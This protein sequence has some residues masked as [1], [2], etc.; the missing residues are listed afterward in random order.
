MAEQADLDGPL[1]DYA[2]KG[3]QVELVGRERVEG[4]DAFKLRVTRKDGSVEVYFLDAGSYLP[5]RV[6]GRRTVRGAEIEGEG[7]VGDYR[8]AGGFLWP[9]SIRN[10]VK[11]RPEKQTVT[12][13]KIE[14]NPPID[15]ARF[16]KPSPKPADA[17]RRD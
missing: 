16:R 13:E 12:I 15:D 7:T 1:V 8:E 6:E 3:H 5:F 17:P 2:A 9:H 4:R 11:G 10:G 14:I